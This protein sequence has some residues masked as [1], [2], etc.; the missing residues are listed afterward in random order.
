MSPS[1]QRQVLSRPLC[2]GGVGDASLAQAVSDSPTGEYVGVWEPPGH[3]SDT[4]EP[5]D[6]ESVVGRYLLFV[7]RLSMSI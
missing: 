1:H 5:S 4:V 6:L 2:G 7:P 3:A